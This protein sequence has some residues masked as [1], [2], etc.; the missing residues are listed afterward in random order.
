[1]KK[2][3]FVSIFILLCIY[4]LGAVLSFLGFVSQ[5]VYFNW[6]GILSGIVTVIGLSSLAKDN[7]DEEVVKKELEALQK[8][9]KATE[10]LKAIEEVRSEREKTITDLEERQ[11]MMEVLVRKASLSLLLREQA[12]FYRERLINFIQENKDIQDSIEKLIELN[13]KQAALNDEIEKDPNVDIL[14]EVIQQ[15]RENPDFDLMKIQKIRNP[16]VRA[17]AKLVWGYFNLFKVN[18]KILK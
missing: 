3:I 11:K 13:D 16:I 17:F 1:M 14:K 10:E 12:K 2:I 9:Q 4:F 18:F 7:F 5:T 15:T 6:A 8:L